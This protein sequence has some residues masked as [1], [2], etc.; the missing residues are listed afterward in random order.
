MEE[1][2]IYV[3][4]QKEMDMHTLNNV[5]MQAVMAM[6]ILISNN[7]EL[8]RQVNRVDQITLFALNT[9]V[10]IAL[11]LADQK[12]VLEASKQVTNT[13]NQLI[14]ASAAK[15]KQQGLEIHQQASAAAVD[16]QVLKQSF[17]DIK[18]SLDSIREFRTNA[19][20]QING[21]ISE[22]NTLSVKAEKTLQ[23]LAS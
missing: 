18:S 6:N 1:H 5:A 10:T 20:P 4:A 9:A 16:V 13:T 15:L 21:V 23:T 17:E 8:I 14:A 3:L 19:I 11:A 12:I 2:I 7:K 22:F